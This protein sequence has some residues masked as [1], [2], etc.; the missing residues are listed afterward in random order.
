MSKCEILLFVVVVVV[1][2]AVVTDIFII[3]I[4][5]IYDY[6]LEDILVTINFLTTFSLFMF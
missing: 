6:I 4:I 1:V 5:I 2:A 3:I